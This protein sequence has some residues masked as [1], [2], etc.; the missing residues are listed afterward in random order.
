MTLPILVSLAFMALA[1][2]GAAPQGSSASAALAA[3]KKVSCDFPLYARGGWKEAEPE[4]EV[5]RT[6]LSFRFEDVDSDGGTARAIG[7][8]GASDIIVR[9]TVTALHFVQSFRDGPLY[10]TTILARQ[11][12]NGRF[13]AVHTRHEYAEIDLPGFTSKPEQYYGTCSLEP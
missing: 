8:F 12:K 7:S 6:S 2:P 9:L 13:L 3:A 4:A 5:K 10:I 1:A 11:V